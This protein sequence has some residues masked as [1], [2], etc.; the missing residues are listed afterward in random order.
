[1]DSSVAAGLY[2]VHASSTSILIH[3]DQPRTR[4][5]L[6]SPCQHGRQVHCPVALA[7]EVSGLGTTRPSTRPSQSLPA[8]SSSRYP[9]TSRQ[10]VLILVTDQDPLKSEDFAS[11]HSTF[12]W[13]GGLSQERRRGEQGSGGPK[14]GSGRFRS[15]SF[16]APRQGS[17]G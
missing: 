5:G 9:V 15:P 7:L 11:A 14:R 12:C 6:L 3:E 16:W 10:A 13:A 1:M 2:P 17:H 4:G 8:S